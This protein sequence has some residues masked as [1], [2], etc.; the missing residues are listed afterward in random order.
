MELKENRQIVI[1][2]VFKNIDK[3]TRNIFSKRLQRGVFRSQEKVEDNHLR[4]IDVEKFLLK[5]T[6]KRQANTPSTGADRNTHL[7]YIPPW[8]IKKWTESNIKKEHI[9]ILT[10]IKKKVSFFNST[11]IDIRSSNLKV[12]FY[13]FILI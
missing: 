3:Q 6:S 5:V 13:D 11:N 4:L 1:Y 10:G 2:L 9:N 12:T 7:S 8:V